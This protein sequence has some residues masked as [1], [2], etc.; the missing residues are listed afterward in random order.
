MSR[1]GREVGDRL[2]PVK[3]ATETMR[4]RLTGLAPLIGRNR[5]EIEMTDSLIL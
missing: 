2:A 3:A 5:A 1:W 4:E